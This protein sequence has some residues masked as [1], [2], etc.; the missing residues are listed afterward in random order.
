MRVLITILLIN[1]NTITNNNNTTTTT[2]TTATTTTTT[3]SNT[4]SNNDS[5]VSCSVFLGVR[6]RGLREVRG[7]GWDWGDPNNS[8][9]SECA[10][11]EEPCEL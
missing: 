4:N 7:L 2:T 9:S 11:F 3:N 6:F 1:N 5:I 10:D 8:P